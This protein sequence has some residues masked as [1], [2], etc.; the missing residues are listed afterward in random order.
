ME[1]MDIIRK[2]D[3]KKLKEAIAN[4]ADVNAR[5]KSGFL[6]LCFASQAGNLEMVKILL[7][8]G[9]D[10]N[11]Q[12]DYDGDTALSRAAN[13][14][15][16][17]LLIEA[18]ATA[19]KTTLFILASRFGQKKEVQKFIK[20]GIDV[21]ATTSQIGETALMNAANAEIAQM[22]IDAGADVN[23]QP[24][25]GFS[26]LINASFKGKEKMVKVLLAAGAEV[27]GRRPVSGETALMFARKAKIARIL[28][29]AGAD[30]NII[31]KDAFRRTPLFRAHNAAVAKVLIDA[32][33]EVNVVCYQGLTPLMRA[34]ML[35]D[36]AM[37]KVLLDAHA[38]INVKDDFGYT[39]LRHANK[40]PKIIRLLTEAARRSSMENKKATD[41]HDK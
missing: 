9:A 32:G 17:R 7:S 5:D 4:G 38:D 13:Q 12:E 18:G 26:P 3:I 16:A 20:Q 22:L 23:A 30:V 2:K 8:A 33:A 41:K 21:D 1:L 25:C 36:A 29:D 11:A 40:R 15:V 19:T 14:K 27:N 31:D 34:A 24:K 28:I 39:A 35:K 6:P 37:V 10:V